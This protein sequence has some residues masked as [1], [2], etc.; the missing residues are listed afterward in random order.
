MSGSGDHYE[1]G[2]LVRNCCGTRSPGTRRRKRSILSGGSIQTNLNG[3][4]ESTKGVRGN[5]PEYPRS[6]T[7]ESEISRSRTLQQKDDRSGRERAK[8]VH[9][10]RRPYLGRA[11]QLLRSIRRSTGN[12]AAKGASHRQ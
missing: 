9:S 3:V 12:R 5:L 11:P 10:C 1:K 4:R 6:G 8:I 7:K 2:L